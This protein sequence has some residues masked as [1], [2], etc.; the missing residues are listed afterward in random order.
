M[1]RNLAALSLVFAACAPTEAPV[2]H[3]PE[4]M[5]EQ[6]AAAAPG[7]PAVV[8]VPPAPPAKPVPLAF[9]AAVEGHC[10][11]LA[12]SRVGATTL[13]H[14][15]NDRYIGELLADGGVKDVT[16]TDIKYDRDRPWLTYGVVEAI[17]GTWPERSLLRYV[18]VAGRMWEGPRYISRAQDGTWTRLHDRERSY[19]GVDRVDRWSD[20]NL[21]GHID[22]QN[23]DGDADCYNKVQFE[24]VRG[25]G[26]APKFTELAGRR[27]REEDC[28]HQ[29]FDLE[30]RETGE[31][32]MLGRF[33]HRPASDG[34]DWFVARHVPGRKLAVDRVPLP[35]D[36]APFIGELAL[37][38]PDELYVAVG[39]GE[40]TRTTHV[41][42]LVDGKWQPPVPLVGDAQALEVDD[43]TVW[44][45]VG[46]TLHRRE[47]DGAFAAASFPTAPVTALGG[48]HERVPWVAQKDGGLWV[49]RGAEFEASSLPPPA[50]AP[51]AT[52]AILDVE[53]FGRDDLW[54]T[55]EYTVKR[56]GWKDREK[57]RALLQ[58][59][60]PRPLLRCAQTA[61]FSTARGLHP[62]PPAAT[63]TCPTIYATLVRADSWAKKDHAYPKLGKLL[64]GRKEFAGVTFSE[65]ELGGV[66]VAGATV[67]DFALAETL[68]RL[69]GEKIKGTRPELLCASP[70]VRRPLPYDLATGKL[71]PGT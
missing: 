18:E 57:R 17:E 21:L 60:P 30:V 62:S 29:L 64:R 42:A 55:T 53:V 70:T 43:S 23:P 33:C 45:L 6:P 71:S 38:G 63:A 68:A 22:C 36:V 46:G 20:G 44:A 10:P 66:R 52:H 11:A 48:F 67:G 50:L 19:V 69:V 3:V 5:P 12:V 34:P 27:D 59:G 40:R 32:A 15:G 2:K 26:K 35:A 41:V 25:P 13:V 9:T 56:P 49:R 51:D 28:H 58:S 65:I 7:E 14:Y 24:V 31:I 1:T 39:F 4:D 16:P 47:P 8:A 54:V 37:R 61:K